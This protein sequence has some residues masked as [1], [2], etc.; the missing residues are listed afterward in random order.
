[1]NIFRRM[2][3]NREKA[4]GL[5]IILEGM[6]VQLDQAEW[7]LQLTELSEKQREYWK[8]RKN[9]VEY[10]KNEVQNAMDGKLHYRSK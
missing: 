8:T 4:E 2:K 3:L 6:K 1:M 7:H 5:H 9:V 10:W